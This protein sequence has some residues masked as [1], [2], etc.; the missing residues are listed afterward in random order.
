[1]SEPKERKLS[2]AELQQFDGLNGH[3]FYIVYKGKVY[4]LSASK[5]WP[6]GKH[7]AQHTRNE[8]LAEAIKAAPHGEDNVFRFPLIGELEEQTAQ[9]LPV[10][11]SAEKKT[12]M[13][14]TPQPV[15]PAS[16]EQTTVSEADGRGRRSSN[17]RGDSGCD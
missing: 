6:L 15:Q 9:V 10:S 3:P 1:M 4:D 14:P 5:L 2:S 13:P 12:V 16:M 17:H 11:P 8:N 7:M